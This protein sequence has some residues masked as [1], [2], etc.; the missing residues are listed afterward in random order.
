VIF[1]DCRILCTEL[2][3]DGPYVTETCSVWKYIFAVST[4][5]LA[6]YFIQLYLWF[7][8]G[9]LSTAEISDVYVVV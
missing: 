8:Y 6:I 9:I 5:F 1:N 7:T 3:D 2:P 4:V